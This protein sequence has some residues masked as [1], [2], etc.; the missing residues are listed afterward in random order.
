M[1]SNN[2][3]LS[4]SEFMRTSS[5]FLFTLNGSQK[6]N[7]L[8]CHIISC[9]LM[10]IVL[11]WGPNHC[12]RENERMGLSNQNDFSPLF[13]SSELEQKDCWEILQAENVFCSGPPRKQPWNLVWTVWAALHSPQWLTHYHTERPDG[14]TTISS[15]RP[16]N[17]TSIQLMRLNWNLTWGSN[18]F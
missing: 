6:R 15:K 4:F 10:E 5:I 1:R 16:H 2:V 8:T 3:I 11:I 12:V 14:T 7:W 17:R 13:W 9:F 18:F